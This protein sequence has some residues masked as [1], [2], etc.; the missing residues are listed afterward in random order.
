MPV[1]VIQNTKLMTNNAMKNLPLFDVGILHVFLNRN[2][3]NAIEMVRKTIAEIISTPNHK[4]QYVVSGPRELS[5]FGLGKYVCSG[6][7]EYV[8][9]GIDGNVR[10]GIG[11]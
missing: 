9:F 8:R 7:I 1:S 2:T 10:F 3:S 4:T 5:K 6:N 11:I